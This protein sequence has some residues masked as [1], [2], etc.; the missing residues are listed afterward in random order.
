MS[1]TPAVE[2]DGVTLSY[3]AAVAAVSG[4]T[5]VLERGQ[6]LA[7]IGPNGAGKSTILRGILGL[8]PATAGEIRVLGTDPVSA[9]P[10]IG[11]M[12]QTDRIDPDFPV[13]VRQVVM[14]GRYRRIG[15]F[16]WPTKADHAAVT[17]ALRTVGLEGHGRRRFGELS[18]GQRQRAILARALACGPEL[19]LLDE[20]FNGLDADSRAALIALLNELKA[21]G[22]SV[23]MSTHDITLAQQAAECVMLV[24]REQIACG[25][26]AETLKLDLIA[27]THP[28]VGVEVDD[29]VLHVPDHEG[30]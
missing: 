4:V 25:P 30:H 15:W 17:A 27:R 13:T 26:T 8:V 19:L 6:G 16:R 14:M 29:H 23:V 28:G 10:R 20:P 12:P 7:L 1:S 18:G 9:R 22:I 5:G 21:G 2:F 3:T 11:Y 24:N